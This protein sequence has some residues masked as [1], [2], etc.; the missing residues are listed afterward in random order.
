MSYI[1]RNDYW[2]IYDCSNKRIKEWK[3]L[4]QDMRS[5]LDKCITLMMEF[6]LRN[7]RNSI[8]FLYQTSLKFNNDLQ[9]M[10][11]LFRPKFII[12][13]KAYLKIWGN[14]IKQ[15][16]SLF[17]E[18]Q[19]SCSIV[20]KEQINCTKSKRKS[21]TTKNIMI[22]SWKKHSTGK[23]DII[24][25]LGITGDQHPRIFSSTQYHSLIN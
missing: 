2:L 14:N 3:Y 19:T 9:I 21:N 20:R 8:V 10:T 17:Q 24:W 11:R 25:F 15:Q 16:S 1:S 12:L 4:I 5:R 23:L 13:I 18:W 22:K 6:M 7:K